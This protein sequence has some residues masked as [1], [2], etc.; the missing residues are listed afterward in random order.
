MAKEGLVR[1]IIDPQAQ[2]G[3]LGGG[4]LEVRYSNVVIRSPQ[5]NPPTHDYLRTL[6]RNSKQSAPPHPHP[7]HLPTTAFKTLMQIT[8]FKNLPLLTVL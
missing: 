2:N 7:Q 4:G 6:P 5:P 3:G 8:G 1:A